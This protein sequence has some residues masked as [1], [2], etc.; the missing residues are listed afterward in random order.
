MA[1]LA[2]HGARVSRFADA[3]DNLMAEVSAD[4]GDNTDTLRF[5]AVKRRA[6]LN[7]ELNKCPEFLQIRERLAADTGFR[8]KTGFTDRF[9]ERL[10]LRA[11][12]ELQVFGLQLA[13]HRERSDIGLAEVGAFF[14]A[15]H[16]HRHVAVRRVVGA[17]HPP[18]NRET[19]DDT[20]KAVI[21]SALRD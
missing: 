16:E 8:V 12:A 1:E 14:H 4:A 17:A 18:E 11:V 9:R 5:I 10:L 20:G 3:A 15:G 13:R 19:G 2:V 6:L 7:V 21:I